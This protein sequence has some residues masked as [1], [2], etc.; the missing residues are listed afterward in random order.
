MLKSREF[1]NILRLE[2]ITLNFYF[3]VTTTQMWLLEKSWKCHTV[4]EP[5]C[6]SNEM[7]CP[8]KEDENGCKRSG[9]CISSEHL[10]I[11]GFSCPPIC[12]P[13]CSSEE[14][15]CPEPTD[16]R[17]CQKLGHCVGSY[18]LDRYGA[19]C[20]PKCNIRCTKNQIMCSGPVDLNGCK[21]ED[22]CVENGT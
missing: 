17:G 2:K 5:N 11:F 16:V 9:K 10:D 6:N 15:F 4:Y 18:E 21:I 14:K 22:Y 12:Q 3:L 19:K 20:P 8:G 7:F 1:P 13:H